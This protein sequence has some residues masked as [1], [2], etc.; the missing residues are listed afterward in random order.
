MLKPN[1]SLDARQSA[2]SLLP[3][4]C[5]LCP[6][7][8]AGCGAKEGESERFPG[9]LYASVHNREC[10]GRGLVM[11]AKLLFEF[12]DHFFRSAQQEVKKL[13][14]IREFGENWGKICDV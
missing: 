7:H 12:E 4:N 1:H 6:V 8:Q 14:L 13:Q 11:Y 2:T 5:R 3:T 9:L 10:T